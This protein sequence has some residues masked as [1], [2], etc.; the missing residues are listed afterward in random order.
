M[1]DSQT[2]LYA[3]VQSW[4]TLKDLDPESDPTLSAIEAPYRRTPQ[5]GIRSRSG[6]DQAL[7]WQLQ[8]EFN[9]F[10]HPDQDKVSGNR[11]LLDQ[12]LAGVARRPVAVCEAQHVTTLL[13]MVEA[14]LGVSAMPS[15]AMP[16][17]DHPTLVSIPL[18]EP[19]VNRTL[20]LVYRRG[21]D[22]NAGFCFPNISAA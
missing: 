11:L 3:G 18:H 4:Q 15:L 16:A 22:V 21:G 20:G 13:G 7:S 8:G 5:V 2:S 10:T 6:V 14:G 17:A 1:G 19:V 9:R 12:A